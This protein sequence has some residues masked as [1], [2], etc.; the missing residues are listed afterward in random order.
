[1]A[2]DSAA[3]AAFEA[4][5][6]SDDADVQSAIEEAIETMG[7]TV[8]GK[9]IV[10]APQSI[11]LEDNAERAGGNVVAV[12]DPIAGGFT[13]LAASDD[14][15]KAW[16]EN[17]KAYSTLTSD[18]QTVKWADVLDAHPELLELEGSAPDS[19][20]VARGAVLLGEGSLDAHTAHDFPTA[21]SGDACFSLNAR[22]E[23]KIAEKYVYHE[24]EPGD[25]EYE[26]IVEN[27]ADKLDY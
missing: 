27:H 9:E 21:N 14:A 24:T 16:L 22:G 8:S 4:Y 6:Q 25:E 3:T 23:R 13:G 17:N 19:I 10:F 7:Y 5:K 2:R 26:W 11:D 12:T 20:V 1:M 15:G 18:E